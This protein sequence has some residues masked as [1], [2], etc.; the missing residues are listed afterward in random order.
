MIGPPVTVFE[1]FSFKKC[2]VSKSDHITTGD[3]INITTCKYHGMEINEVMIDKLQAISS[4]DVIYYVSLPVKRFERRMS[5]SFQYLI[6]DID[7]SL[8]SQY[9][10]QLIS[11]CIN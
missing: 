6:G 5:R 7:V 4:Y 1:E 8:R 3:M 9:I 10:Q 11:K 2:L